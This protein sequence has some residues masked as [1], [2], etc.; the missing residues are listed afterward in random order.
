M[1]NAGKKG[2]ESLEL[3]MMSEEKFRVE[4]EEL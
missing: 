2:E 4:N 3:R 1:L